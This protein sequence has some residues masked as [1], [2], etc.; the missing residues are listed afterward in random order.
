MTRDAMT[1]DE[2]PGDEM[3]GDEITRSLYLKKINR[4]TTETL[5]CYVG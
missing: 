2:M 1:R 3:A 5:S 4:Y